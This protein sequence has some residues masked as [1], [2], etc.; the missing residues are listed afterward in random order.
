MKKKLTLL[1]ATTVGMIA[2]TGSL[3]KAFIP[4]T[5]LVFTDIAGS[6][7]IHQ[8]MPCG[9]PLDLMDPIQEGQMDIT[10]EIIMRDGEI[11]G[12]PMFDL[13]RMDLFL[14]PFSVRRNCG[15]GLRGIAEFTEIGLKLAGAV[16]FPGE[17]TGPLGSMMFRFTI[18]KENFLILESILDNAPVPQPEKK[19]QRPSEDVTGLI[20][21]RHKTVQIHIVLTTDLHFQALCRSGKCG[22]DEIDRGTQTADVRGGSPTTTCTSTRPPGNAFRVFT[23]DDPAPTLRLGTFVLAN[24]EVFQLQQ[25]GQPGVRLIRTSNSDIRHFQVGPGEAFITATDLGGDVQVVPCR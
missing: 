4:H 15:M 25:T 24:G 11:I 1:V 9:G 12:T 17:E 6:V 21:L 3:T 2:L 5:P 7:G 16:R 22:I 20:D 18:P 19:Y 14:K 23:E 10:P 8:E 13:T